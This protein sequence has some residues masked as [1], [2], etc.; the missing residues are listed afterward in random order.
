MINIH[1]VY[2][3]GESL[4]ANP[5]IDRRIHPV[6]Y[7]YIWSEPDQ[8]SQWRAQDTSHL[9]RSETIEDI[10]LHQDIAL[11]AA[12]LI[13]RHTGAGLKTIWNRRDN[14][15]KNLTTIEERV[16]KLT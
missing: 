13:A 4:V 11:E 15:E 10:S 2:K 8:I 12:L 1:V 16:R 14:V 5:D 3:Q 9:R 7:I 6:G